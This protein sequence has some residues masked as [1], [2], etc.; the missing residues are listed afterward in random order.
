MTRFSFG[1]ETW[2]GFATNKYRLFSANMIED[3]EF[4]WTLMYLPEPRRIHE[5][6]ENVRTHLQCRSISTR[7]DAQW[8]RD[9]ANNEGLW[10]RRWWPWPGPG[11][12]GITAFLSFPQRQKLHNLY[13]ERFCELCKIAD[14]LQVVVNI[15]DL[16]HL[17]DLLPQSKTT[18][19]EA[20]WICTLC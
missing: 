11:T 16:P 1:G 14:A 9:C 19:Y 4:R 15:R 3:K 13:F 5:E 2:I 6:P 7:R 20:K 18:R 10:T 12:L 17:S 8:R